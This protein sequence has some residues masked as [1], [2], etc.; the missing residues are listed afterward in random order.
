M[1]DRL[2]VAVVPP[3][4]VVDD[5][6]RYVGPRR[7]FG[8]PWRWSPARNWHVTL[9]FLGDVDAGLQ[10]P[11]AELL[12]DVA[13][14]TGPFSFA[15]G[16][17]LAFPD[18]RNAK[19]LALAATQG[20]DDMGHLARRVRNACSRAGAQPDGARFTPH[21]TLARNG[22]GASARALLE[23]ADSFGTFAW[24]VGGFALFASTLAPSGARY[25]VV[26]RFDF[27]PADGS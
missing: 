1:T 9:A 14:T 11:L 12:A 2:F 13:A 15:S 19:V 8:A 22:R 6:E 5:L 17:A 18:P 3:Q 23:V 25:N 20:A 16:G 26:E 27:P 4:S 21:L 7:D 24:T 10:E